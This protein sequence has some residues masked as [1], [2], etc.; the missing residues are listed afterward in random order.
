MTWLAPLALLGVVALGVPILIHLFGRRVARRLKFPSLRLMGEA[1]PTPATRSVPSDLLLLVARCAIVLA[2]VLALAQPLFPTV[3]RDREA[4]RPVRVILVDTSTSMR[5]ATGNGSAMEAARALGRALLDSSRNGMIVESEHPGAS[6]AG[7]ASWLESQAGRREVVVISDFQAGALHDGQVAAIPADIGVR[8]ERMVSSDRLSAAPEGVAAVDS[9]IADSSGTYAAWRVDRIDSLS[10]PAMLG[11]ADELA[12]VRADTAVLRA[13]FRRP[14]KRTERIAVVLPGYPERSVLANESAVLDS[15]WQ[16][17]LLVALKRNRAFAE[18]ARAATV[19]SG[20]VLPGTVVAINQ[21]G[22]PI[23]STSRARAGAPHEIL[24]FSCAEA[25]SLGAIGLIAGLMIALD[26]VPPLTEL[27]PLL[28]PDDVLQRWQREPVG[29]VPRGPDE[30]SPDGRWL[31]L[32]A[33]ILLGAEEWL[34]R[35]SPRRVA[36]TEPEVARARV[37]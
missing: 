5:R 29:S 1:M 6:L 12:R 23:A 19:V 26:S 17:N 9:L 33:L 27:E 8:L 22:A 36:K 7:A 25:G 18:I 13:L 37:A 20:C 34:R 11:S 16:G 32:T 14:L 21:S 10:V 24:V 31:W 2:A 28:L 35:R 3:R 4:Q 30:T 15:P